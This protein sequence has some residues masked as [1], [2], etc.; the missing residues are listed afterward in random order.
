LPSR[1]VV[2]D[3]LNNELFQNHLLHKDLEVIGD[4]SYV[5]MNQSIQVP[6]IIE[7]E[8]Q[9]TR[10]EEENPTNLIKIETVESTR[11]SDPLKF[12][13]DVEEILSKKEPDCDSYQFHTREARTTNKSLNIEEEKVQEILFKKEAE[14]VL[15]PKKVDLRKGNSGRK[16]KSLEQQLDDIFNNITFKNWLKK[17]V[18][19]NAT[20]E[21]EIIL[22]CHWC[23]QCGFNNN[24][25]QGLL[26]SINGYINPS[27]NMTRLY[28]H[29]KT[30]KKHKEARMVLTN[31]TV[32]FSPL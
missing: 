11:I 16:P 20:G 30:N 31:N 13:E 7:K 6:M 17:D 25:S 8:S 4:Y 28:E 29:A 19:M 23:K 22:Y 2:D 26:F 27:L 32:I 18:Q 12:M 9:D 1:E 14:S 21:T 3:T 10:M 15:P 5:S 24:L